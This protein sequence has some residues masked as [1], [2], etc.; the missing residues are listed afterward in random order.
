ME[1]QGIDILSP[2]GGASCGYRAGQYALSY[3]HRSM[4]YLSHEGDAAWS[5]NRLGGI[6]EAVEHLAVGGAVHACLTHGTDARGGTQSTALLEQAMEL[7]DALLWITDTDALANFAASFLAG[8]GLSIPSSRSLLSF[9]DTAIACAEGINSYDFDWAAV[10]R[11]LVD[12]LAGD[13]RTA[14]HSARTVEG[15]VTERGSV[16]AADT[17]A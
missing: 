11:G 13:A 6:R 10:A 4:V 8:R 2:A 3:G 1:P 15:A 9:G 7:P 17:G 14:S 16:Q 12:R 5:M